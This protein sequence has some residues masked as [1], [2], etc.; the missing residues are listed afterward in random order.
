MNWNDNQ[1]VSWYWLRA[2]LGV[3]C[4]E[5][6]QPLIILFS[7]LDK[8]TDLRSCETAS[9]RVTNE[10]VA[11]QSLQVVMD[12]EQKRG[13]VI[14]VAFPA[15]GNRKREQEKIKK[16][17]VVKEQVE[18]MR[19]MI[20]NTRDCVIQSLGQLFHHNHNIISDVSVVVEFCCR[21]S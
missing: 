4:Q 17:Q 1:D 21:H 9:S 3:G 15:D 11:N 19:W 18:Q 8:L 16:Y 7:W 12:K 10:L 5:G 6:T 14:D 13:A 20:G 2:E